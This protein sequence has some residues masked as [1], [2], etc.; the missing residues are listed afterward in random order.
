M[1]I[2][3]KE[4]WSIEKTEENE[5]ERSQAWVIRH[6]RFQDCREKAELQKEPEKGQGTQ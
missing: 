1:I 4:E 6:T 5:R 2:E 3:E